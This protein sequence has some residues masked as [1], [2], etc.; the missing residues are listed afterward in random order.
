MYVPPPSPPVFPSLPPSQLV[1][2]R[3]ARVFNDAGINISEMNEGN[4]RKE[5]QRQWEKEMEVGG[6]QDMRFLQ[7][8]TQG[9]R[10]GKGSYPL[11]Y[12][13][14]PASPVFPAMIRSGGAEG[15]YISS[16]ALK[17]EEEQA[18]REGGKRPLGDKGRVVQ[19]CRHR[20]QC[21]RRPSVW[22][23]RRNFPVC[24]T[25]FFLTDG[26][27]GV[28]RGPGGGWELVGGLVGLLGGR[29]RDGW[30]GPGACSVA[31]RWV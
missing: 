14:T 15:A 4:E 24:P 1:Y 23:K 5:V 12:F 18:A 19:R 20:T 25:L 13:S 21:C 31:W 26:P 30:D 3:G 9:A 27:R 2:L 16:Y 8:S 10:D 29:W 28:G 6:Q 7:C 22:E 17:N 11:H